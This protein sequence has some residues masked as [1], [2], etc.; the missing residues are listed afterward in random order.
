MTKH[1]MGPLVRPLA[2][3]VPR[4]LLGAALLLPLARPALAQS[5]PKIRI[6]VPTKAYWPT[7]VAQATER[8]GLFTRAGI[9][10]ETTIYRGG[11]EC[12]EAL[13]AGAADVILDPPSLVAAGLRR[14]VGSR[15][16]AG[17]SLAYHGWHLMVRA[18]SAIQSVAQLAGQKVGITSRGS[19]SD[20]LAQWTAQDRGL[21][22]TAVPV[23]GGGLVPNLR[24]RNL[25]AAVIYS[26]LSFQ[27]LQAGQARSLIDYGKAVPPHC[28]AGWIAS[29]RIIQSQPVAV[30]ATLD[31]LFGGLAWLR[32]SRDEAIALIA[33]NNE[34]PTAIAAAEYQETILNLDP[35]GGLDR[36][37][38]ALSLE[39]AR[40]GG[41]TDMA[42]VEEV[43]TE[44]FRPARAG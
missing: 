2:H 37:Q 34:I 23:G 21:A 41:M 43:Y 15:L 22:F 6:G 24:S 27:L 36:Q 1:P 31:A 10:A 13:A 25:D 17:A 29:D 39:L 9:E 12:F 18:D 14:G 35:A 8:Q 40:L 11:A 33:E 42:P 32:A 7:I 3:P 44:R 38:I 4:R 5:R 30:Q 16:V 19:G 26:P 20:L 28:T